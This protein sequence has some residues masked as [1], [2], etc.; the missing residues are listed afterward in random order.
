MKI[1]VDTC[2]YV[3]LFEERGSK[4]ALAYTFFS[5]GWNC[6]F[7]LVVSDWNRSELKRR[8]LDSEFPQLFDMFKAKNKLH[9]VEHTE[10]ELN[11]SKSKGEHW[12][13]YLHYLIAKKSGCDK[14]VTRDNDFISS[15]S[16]IFDIVYPEQ[17]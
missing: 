7:E 11:I 8:K 6:A 15:L 12:Q 14:I 3:D 17:I 5:K 4:A 2:V 10:E 13:D 9:L 1:Y 16:P